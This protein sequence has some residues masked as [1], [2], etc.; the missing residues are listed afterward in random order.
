MGGFPG[1]FPVFAVG[2][3]IVFGPFRFFEIAIGFDSNIFFAGS[4]PSLRGRD[5]GGI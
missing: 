5:Q 2:V 3:E 1:S 4:F